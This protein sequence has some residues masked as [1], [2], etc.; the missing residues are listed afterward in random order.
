MQL[1]CDNISAAVSRR[2]WLMFVVCSFSLR[3]FNFFPHV[4]FVCARNKDGQDRI[5][6]PLLSFHC[7]LHGKHS[8]ILAGNPTNKMDWTDRNWVYLAC[9]EQ[10]NFHF[11]L[12][13]K[14]TP[15]FG[16]LNVLYVILLRY[17]HYFQKKIL[18]LFHTVLSVIISR[19]KCPT[20][21]S[22]GWWQTD[23]WW[24]LIC[25]MPGAERAGIFLEPSGKGPGKY[26]NCCR[27]SFGGFWSVLGAFSSIWTH[28]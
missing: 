9:G 10:I 17:E 14:R 6:F 2:K 21:W 4:C 16:L 25:Q 24:S 19:L 22:W 8:P 11:S 26:I 3:F 7:S 23:Q 20:Y 1:L 18:K 28:P 13:C 15:I 12:R 27:E 5:I